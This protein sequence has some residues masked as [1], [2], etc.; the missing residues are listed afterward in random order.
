MLIYGLGFRIGEI[1][2]LKIQDIDIKAIMVE[3][4]I[5][6]INDFLKNTKLY[7]LITRERMKKWKIYPKVW[8][9]S[10]FVI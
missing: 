4:S 7:V 10:K 8:I 1:E 6:F 5:L 3:T 9:L 2:K